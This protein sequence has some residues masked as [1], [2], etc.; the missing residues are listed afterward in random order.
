MNCCDYFQ[1]RED[2]FVATKSKTGQN[3]GRRPN[4]APS[5]REALLAVALPSFARLGFEGVDLRGLAALAKVDASLIGHS[6]GSKF[7]LWVAVI[8]QLAEEQRGYSTQF[9]AFQNTSIPAKE[10]MTSFLLWFTERSFEKPYLSMLILRESLNPGPRL[11][12]LMDHLLRPFYLQLKPLLEKVIEQKLSSVA[13]SATLFF[14]LV[15]SISAQVASQGALESLTGS[16]N[17]EF[18]KEVQQT[19]VAVFVQQ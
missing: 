4:S 7:A 11:D 18:M 15:N 17:P 1:W 14:L 12:L 3:R 13:D 2:H 5:G 10:R 9:V 16:C 19:A 6:F 8:D